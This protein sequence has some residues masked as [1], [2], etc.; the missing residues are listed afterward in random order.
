MM[1]DPAFMSRVLVPLRPAGLVKRMLR[2]LVNAT[3]DMLRD[4]GFAEWGDAEATPAWQKVHAHLLFSSVFL[5]SCEVAASETEEDAALGA[6]GV[7]ALAQMVEIMESKQAQGYP[8][9][10]F[11]LKRVINR[12]NDAGNSSENIE[13]WLNQVSHSLSVC[14]H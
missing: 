9:V 10:V 4:D 3:T 1:M 12:L 13:S 5:L 6:D 7:A 8:G 14:C 2:N 11:L